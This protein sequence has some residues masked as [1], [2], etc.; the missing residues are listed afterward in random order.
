MLQVPEECLRPPALA[1]CLEDPAY[2][3]L[4]VPTTITSVSGALWDV[5]FL[6][7]RLIVSANVTLDSLRLRVRRHRRCCLPA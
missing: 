6:R 1:A 7:R 4:T 2:V 5:G 3:R